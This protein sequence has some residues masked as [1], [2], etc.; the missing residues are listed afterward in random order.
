MD[1]CEAA[2]NLQVSEGQVAGLMN[3]QLH[4]IVLVLNRWR[5]G[6]GTELLRRNPS[7]G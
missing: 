5:D 4:E 7:E 2:Q 1:L 3:R 6:I